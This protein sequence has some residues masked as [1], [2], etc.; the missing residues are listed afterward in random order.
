MFKV[1]LLQDYLSNPAMSSSDLKQVLRSPAHYIAYKADRPAETKAQ[2][3]GS[4]A[5]KAILEP[6]FYHPLVAPKVDRRTK[7]GKLAWEQFLA[8][9]V[10]V[11]VLDQDEYVA[12]EGMIA[13]V[14]ESPEAQRLLKT[15]VAEIS[16]YS[17]HGL[18]DIRCR[19]DWRCDERKLLVNLKTAEDASPDAFERQIASYKYHLQMAVETFICAMIWQIPS[20]DIQYRWLVV[21]K[22]PPYA[23]S[24]FSPDPH[25]LATGFSA[26]NRAVLLWEDAVARDSIAESRFRYNEEVSLPRWAWEV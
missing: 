14:K 17:S 6:R 25:M 5:H 23:V 18:I 10:D 12:V 22:E 7:E 3:F 16:A 9:A 24:V 15:G 21:E 2:R 19:P 1:E 4:L 8:S 13:A 20:T 11:D 26:L